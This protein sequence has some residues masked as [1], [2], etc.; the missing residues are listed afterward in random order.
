MVIELIDPS[1]M[2]TEPHLMLDEVND[3]LRP[4]LGSYCFGQ[5]L[6]RFGQ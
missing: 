3:P 1:D 5:N 2:E 6:D 4:R